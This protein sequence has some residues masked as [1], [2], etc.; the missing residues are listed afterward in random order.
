MKNAFLGKKKS[1]LCS[2][3]GFLE[4]L[5]HVADLTVTGA[6]TH[7]DSKILTF[8]HAES[9]PIHV[10]ADVVLHRLL[11]VRYEPHMHVRRVPH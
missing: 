2:G 9:L 7:R 10:L 3:G 8:S 11:L 1:A 6:R 4:E 5:R